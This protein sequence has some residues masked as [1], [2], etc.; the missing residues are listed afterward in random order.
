M[1]SSPINLD[2]ILEKNGLGQSLHKSAKKLSKFEIQFQKINP[3][4]TEYTLEVSLVL[5]NY[6]DLIECGEGGTLGLKNP[7]IF[8]LGDMHV[9]DFKFYFIKF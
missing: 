3:N 5:V 7:I 8:L 1:Q 2:T 4:Q 6:E 9:S